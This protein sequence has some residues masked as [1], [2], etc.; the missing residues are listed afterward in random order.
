MKVKLTQHFQSLKDHLIVDENSEKDT[1]RELEDHAK[2]RCQE[3]AGLLAG[4]W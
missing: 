1:I 3:K 2:D 4:K